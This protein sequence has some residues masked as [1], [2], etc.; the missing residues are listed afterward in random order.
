MGEG[1]TPHGPGATAERV[2]VVCVPV[3]VYVRVHE[4]PPGE[5]PHPASTLGCQMLAGDF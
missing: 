2:L 1:Q 5:M 3:G 4:R